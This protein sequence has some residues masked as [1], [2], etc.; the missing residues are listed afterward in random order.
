[1]L[2]RFLFIVFSKYSLFF[3]VIIGNWFLITCTLEQISG[4]MV[5]YLN[6]MPTDTDLNEDGTIVHSHKNCLEW[7]VFSLHFCPYCLY[8]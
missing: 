4:E 5:H 7:L 8:L 2:L 6:G 1:M 3:L